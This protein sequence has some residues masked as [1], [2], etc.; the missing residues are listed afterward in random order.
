MFVRFGAKLILYHQKST[1]VAHAWVR[2]LLRVP[3]PSPV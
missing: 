1:P 2:G 3:L